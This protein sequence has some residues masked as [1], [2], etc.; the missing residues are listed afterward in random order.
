MAKTSTPRVLSDVSKNV[1]PVSN[2]T[3]LRQLGVDETFSPTAKMV[4]PGLWEV[5]TSVAPHG[6]KND[7]SLPSFEIVA[8][9]DFR[10]ASPEE[11]QR[12]ALRGAI[13]D[14]QRNWRDAYKSNAENATNAAQWSRVNVKTDVID[15]TR[16]KADPLAKAKNAVNKLTPAQV[17]ELIAAM[18]ANM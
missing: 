18:N 11:V 10:T 2:A 5:R 4:E 3:K 16:A 17:A 6:V 14:V 7:K 15:A 1:L 8:T 13:I 12:L 9:Y